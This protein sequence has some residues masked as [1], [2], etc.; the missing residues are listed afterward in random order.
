MP[1]SLAG[2][3]RK[4]ARPCCREGFPWTA[5]RQKGLVIGLLRGRSVLTSSD[6]TALAR[7]AHRGGARRLAGAQAYR[8]GGDSR[9][10]VLRRNSRSGHSWSDLVKVRAIE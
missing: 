7:G 4:S 2:E 10:Q 1:A 6:R 3:R 8:N 5:S 9:W